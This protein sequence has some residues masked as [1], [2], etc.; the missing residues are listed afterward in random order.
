MTIYDSLGAQQEPLYVD[1]LNPIGKDYKGDTLYD[2]EYHD[3][4]NYE[5]YNFKADD[6]LDFIYF[7]K[8]KDKD[9]ILE[10]FATKVLLDNPVFERGIA[11]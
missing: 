8:N 1:E 3:I 11:R 5:N 7:L 10:N 4:Y 2:H 6:V 9:F